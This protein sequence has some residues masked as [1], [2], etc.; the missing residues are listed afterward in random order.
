M[1]ILETAL[2]FRIAEYSSLEEVLILDIY[3][4]VICVLKIV[5]CLVSCMK[6]G[7]NYQMYRRKIDTLEVNQKVLKGD[8]YVIKSTT[9]WDTFA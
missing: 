9:S 1:Y 5:S 7:R 3:S 6:Q 2:N 4:Y 8:F